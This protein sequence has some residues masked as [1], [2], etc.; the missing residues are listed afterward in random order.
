MIDYD[1]ISHETLAFLEY[2]KAETPDITF[3][4]LINPAERTVSVYAQKA[5]TNIERTVSVYAQKATTNIERYSERYT[6]YEFLQ[7]SFES[8][9]KKLVQR[10]RRD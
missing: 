7:S 8:I 6:F 10:F 9:H 2:A 1:R 3:V 4:T 5:T